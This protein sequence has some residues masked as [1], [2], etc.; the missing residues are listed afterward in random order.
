MATKPTRVATYYRV[1]REEQ[2]PENQ[3]IQLRNPCE[4]WEDLTYAKGTRGVN[5]WCL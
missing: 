4:R 3:L 2:E 1:T 5:P